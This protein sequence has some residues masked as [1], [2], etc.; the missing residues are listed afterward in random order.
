VSGFLLVC[1]PA[2][3]SSFKAVQ[4]IRSVSKEKRV[5][6]AGTLDPFATGLLVIAIG[7]QF[8]KQID[9][10]QGMGKRY[11]VKMI[12][13]ITTDTLDSY[14]AITN[15]SPSNDIQNEIGEDP[16]TLLP[17]NVQAAFDSIMGESLQVPPFYS[18]RKVNGKRL[19]KLARKGEYVEAEARKVVVSDLEIHSYANGRFPVVCFS[20]TCSKG[21]YIRALVRDIGKALNLPAYTKDLVRTSIG[22][23]KLEDAIHLSKAETYCDFLFEKQ[24]TNATI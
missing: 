16:G 10:F 19:Y 22:Q 17:G 20:V 11:C 8:T 13:G 5:G 23:Y 1:K 7:R 15:I 12:L 21:T 18:A 4:R 14:G 3:L 9:H 2:G 24:R 6:H